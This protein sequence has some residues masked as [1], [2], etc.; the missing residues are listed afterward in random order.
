MI[1]SFTK[2]WPEIQKSEIPPS[3]F[4]PI[5]GDWEKLEIPNLAQTS[6]IKCYRTLQNARVTAFTVSEL[7]R[8]NQQGGVKLL[9][10]TQIRVNNDF[11]KQKGK[12]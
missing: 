5:S 3:E 2:D 10:P 1:I 9:S 7:L 8:E 6:L 12:T 11:E 4:F